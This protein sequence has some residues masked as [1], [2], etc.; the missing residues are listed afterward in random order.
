MR[1]LKNRARQSQT[2]T[3]QASASSQ[4][5]ARRGGLLRPRRPARRA[6]PL[7]RRGVRPRP[8]RRRAR[9]PGRAA[10]P[11]CARRRLPAAP[12]G[13][14][15]LGVAARRGEAQAAEQT[16]RLGA[17]PAEGGERLV[18]QRKAARLHGRQARRAASEP[19][20]GLDRRA[21][22]RHGAQAALGQHQGRRRGAR[23]RRQPIRLR[24]PGRGGAVC[25]G[26]GE[27]QGFR[28]QQRRQVK[29]EGAKADAQRFQRP[30]LG[31]GQG[32][33]LGLDKRRST[34]PPA[35]IS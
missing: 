28:R 19:L 3:R 21:E 20:Q 17:G 7:A 31:D 18:G 35:S 1:V 11:P 8:G 27:S 23:Q 32:L 30:A 16:H 12:Q 14:L 5:L 25:E 33:D 15:G 34:T 4:E 29:A 10:W 13:V 6:A 26:R 2:S 22:A 24:P 9:P